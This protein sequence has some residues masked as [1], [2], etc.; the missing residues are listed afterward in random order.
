MRL[1]NVFLTFGKLKQHLK[2][3]RS[4]N[5]LKT[6]VPKTCRRCFQRDKPNTSSTSV[7]RLPDILKTEATPE[8]GTTCERR[9]YLKS[10]E[11]V[12]SVTNLRRPVRLQNVFMTF[13][14]LNNTLNGHVLILCERRLY[15]KHGTDV[16]NVTNRRRPVRLQNVFLTF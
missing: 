9:F 7:K 1:Q 12:S 8:T 15:L 3:T 16:S 13:R 5:V 10:F 4:D 2:W 6:F 11:D 14:K